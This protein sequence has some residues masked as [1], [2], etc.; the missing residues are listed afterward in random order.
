LLMR[1]NWQ[2]P[3]LVTLNF[4]HVFFHFACNFPEIFLLL[5]LCFA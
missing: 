3:M 1:N 2:Q 4:F 5:K